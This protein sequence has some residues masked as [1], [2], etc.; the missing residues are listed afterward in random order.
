MWYKS[1]HLFSFSNLACIVGFVEVLCSETS[2]VSGQAVE[3]D[4]KDEEKY[5]LRKRTSY[6]DEMID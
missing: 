1:N 4:F 5:Q 2:I 3:T 6:R